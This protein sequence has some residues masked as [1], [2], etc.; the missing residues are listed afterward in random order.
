MSWTTKQNKVFED[1]LATFDKE[2]PDCWQNLAR[3]VGGK[4]VDEVKCHYQKLVQDIDHIEAGKIPLP[5][6][7]SFSD[8]KKMTDDQEQRLKSLKI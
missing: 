4:T 8:Y 7:G 1:A 6:Y 3:A 5:A 2:R